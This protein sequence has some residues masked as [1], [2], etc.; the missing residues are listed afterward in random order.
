MSTI[1]ADFVGT[2]L[3]P[4]GAQLRMHLLNGTSVPVESSFASF[5]ASTSQ[6]PVKRSFRAVLNIVGT[7]VSLPEQVF[8]SDFTSGSGDIQNA[9]G[10][11]WPLVRFVCDSLKDAGYLVLEPVDRTIEAIVLATRLRYALN[12]AGR[13]RLVEK[14]SNKVLL[15]IN[16]GKLERSE[17]TD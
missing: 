7:N 6:E 11:H 16:V 14:P 9:P 5:Q 3:G 13:C 4:F 12:A 15:D 1:E 17:Y 2:S 10:D 8:Q